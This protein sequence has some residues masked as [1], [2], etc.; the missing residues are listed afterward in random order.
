[1]FPAIEKKHGGP[2]SKWMKAVQAL[3]D[4]KYADQMNV[5]QKNHGFSRAHANAIVM[6]VRG[7]STSKRHVSPDAYFA[8]IDAAAAKTA[9]A[10]FDAVRTTNPALDL[11][12][13]W[14]QP[15]L[16]AQ[17]GYVLGISAAKNHLTVNPFS[18]HV[19]ET[20]AESLDDLGVAKHTFKV[21]IGWKVDAPLLRR[22]VKARLRELE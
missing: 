13:A 1:M 17:R 15:V 14:N 19:I 5:L 2:I 16:K 8:S 11:V 22:L 10:M 9:R 18:K 20:F 6:S 4:A 7:S 3:G 21:P 12:V